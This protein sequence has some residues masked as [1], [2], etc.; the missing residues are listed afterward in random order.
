VA[1]VTLWL[2]ARCRAYC[3]WARRRVKSD[4][5]LPVAMLVYA[6]SRAAFRLHTK[7]YE[8]AAKKLMRGMPR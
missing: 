3:A 4:T 2:M 5:T 6:V 7:L 1:S 8:R